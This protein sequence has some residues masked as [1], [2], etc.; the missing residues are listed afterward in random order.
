MVP[1]CRILFATA[2]GREYDVHY[3]NRSHLGTNPIALPNGVSSLGQSAVCTAEVARDAEISSGLQRTIGN[4][5]VAS[6]L[7]EFNIISQ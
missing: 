6:A 7:F 5:E 4:F 2:R 1:V 3:E